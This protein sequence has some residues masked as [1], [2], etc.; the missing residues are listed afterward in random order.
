MGGGGCDFRGGGFEGRGKVGG[1]LEENVYGIGDGF[2]G[3]IS[4]GGVGWMMV[5]PGFV[6]NPS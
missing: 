6:F 3:W 2:G 1:W 4:W 5:K